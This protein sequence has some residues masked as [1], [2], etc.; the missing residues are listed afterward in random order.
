MTT[1][2]HMGSVIQDVAAMLAVTPPQV[3]RQWADEATHRA[4]QAPRGD[5]RA[6]GREAHVARIVATL[7]EVLHEE[8]T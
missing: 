2:R 7:V 6:A 8:D 5:W 1:T 3:A 4:S